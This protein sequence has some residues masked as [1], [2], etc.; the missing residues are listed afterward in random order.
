MIKLFFPIL[1]LIISIQNS[2]TQTILG[3]S[4]DKN[5][6]DG[7][8]VD[9]IAI[10]G[11]DIT[12]KEIILREL[13]FNVGDTIN[14]KILLY[15]S[16]RI[17]SLGI[18]TKVRLFRDPLSF[19]KNVVQ[20]LVNESWYIYPIPLAELKD[21]DWK[22]ISYGFDLVL[23]NFRGR[24][25][26]LRARA[27]F[28]YD[29]SLS[30][31]Y[32]NPY[33]IWKDNISLELNLSYHDTKNISSTAKYLYGGDFNQK[34]VSAGVGIG[35]RFGLFQKVGISFNYNYIQ[36]PAYIKGISASHDRIDRLF[37]IGASYSYDTR[38]LR[39]FAREGILGSA[40]YE[41]KGLGIDDINYQIAS[42]DFREYR[43]LFGELGAK[44]RLASRFTMGNL[45]PFYD[46]SYLGFRERIRGHFNNESE[47]NN[48][49]LASLELN[50]PVIK[51]FNIS[52]D[53]IPIIPKQLLSY[54]VALYL[55]MFGDTGATQ[56]NG[57]QIS[58]KDFQSGYGMGLTLLIL[59]YN[60][61]RF[62][63]AFNENLHS[64]FIFD[65]GTSF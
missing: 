31:S 46:Y 9:S 17:F 39:Q 56:L 32:S 19:P 60:I 11:N 47:G 25:E 62:E 41:L 54:R 16:E 7:F 36:S 52:L 29:P 40:S 15:N 2:F 13:T 20:I 33:F 37:S 8:V 23:Q 5:L 10:Q 28:G 50:Y 61:V 18:F 4:L 64:E 27:L 22:K 12:E 24:N 57:H 43:K 26:T 6:E 58:I 59:P 51:D 48:L 34:F 42:I 1:F 3:T 53:F 55:Q 63:V 38:D 65:I 14:N 49:Y 45:V 35:K 44:W 30:I 21:R